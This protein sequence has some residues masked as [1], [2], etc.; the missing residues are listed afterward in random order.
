MTDH[1]ASV[2]K[3]FLKQNEQFACAGIFERKKDVVFRTRNNY[4]FEIWLVKA[5]SKAGWRP[6]TAS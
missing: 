5:L 6:S 1:I 2:S 3:R 4:S